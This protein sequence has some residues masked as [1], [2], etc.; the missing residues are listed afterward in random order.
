MSAMPWRSSAMRHRRVPVVDDR[1]LALVL[2]VPEDVVRVGHRRRCRPGPC[3]SASRCRSCRRCRAPCSASPGRTR[4]SGTSRPDV[5]D[6]GDVAVVERPDQ[7]GRDH[8][9]DLV[10]AREVDVVGHLAGADLGQ[11][12]VGVVERRDR[13]LDVVLRVLLLERLDR[14]WGR[15][16]RRSCRAAASRS[17]PAAC[18]RRSRGLSGLI[19][20]VTG[21]AARRSCS[22]PSGCCPGSAPPADEQL[23]QE[24]AD[25]RRRHCGQGGVLQHAAPRETSAP[26]PGSEGCAGTPRGR[27]TFGS[28]RRSSR[29][30]LPSALLA[31][32]TE[33][34]ID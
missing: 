4:G 23:R 10:V 21:S 25:G 11:R 6:V 18:R 3:R 24:G 20:Q 17:S 13:D 14:R 1:D 33:A 19:G 26:A 31:G 16:S 15:C 29:T 7:L 9:A 2:R 30:D 22:A 8:L 27:R 28:C 32:C 34:C 5:G 12:L